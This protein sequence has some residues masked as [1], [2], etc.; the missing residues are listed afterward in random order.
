[1]RWNCWPGL[2]GALVAMAVAGQAAA[3]VVVTTYSGT[4][5]HGT[6]VTGVFGT[7]G[8]DLSGLPFVAVFETDATAPGAVTAFGATSSSIGGGA[9]TPPV[10]GR[11]VIN[12]IAQ[13]FDGDFGL[14]TQTDDGVFEAFTHFAS[15]HA[16]DDDYGT[17][18]AG[19]SGSG[20]DFLPDSDWRTFGASDLDLVAS[21]FGS[22]DIF[23]YDAEAGVLVRRA[24][25][26]LDVTGVSVP[27]PQAWA[28]MI[29]G[30]AGMGA[31][32]RYRRHTPAR[33]SQ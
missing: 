7:A 29:L 22:V 20:L 26:T 4:V 33:S 23:E 1:M 31:L 25:A 21:L 30:F 9:P 18:M 2:A 10:T 8:A 24:F 6:D 17:L 28:L 12:G 19:G 32:L 16:S 13:V 14:Q 3:A 15:N 11:I 27:E 5:A